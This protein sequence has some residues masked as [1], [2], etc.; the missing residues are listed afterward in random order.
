MLCILIILHKII[1]LFGAVLI[2][3]MV[4]AVTCIS[5]TCLLQN[6]DR[7][8]F[9]ELVTVSVNDRVQVDECDFYQMEC[10]N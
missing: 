6:N 7:V 3:L 9:D 10:V 2:S 8:Y 1:L 4:P 5:Y